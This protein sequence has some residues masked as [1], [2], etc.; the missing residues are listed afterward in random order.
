[1][2]APQTTWATVTDVAT[3]TGEDVDAV[4]LNLANAIVEDHA[5]RLYELDSTRVRTRDAVWLKRAVAWQ[6]AWL[7]GQDDLLTRMNITEISESG[8]STTF[9][10][11]AFTLAP[12]AKRC[13]NNC[14]FRR[15][16]SLH[17]RSP[18]V[19]GRVVPSAAATAEANDPYEQW[20][21]L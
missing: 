11:T 6:A 17:I 14:S 9:D 18:F 13:L 7:P 5:R 15:S 8:Q 10:P 19:D 12:M 16:R 2:S 3:I 4:I 21:P 1:M 20:R